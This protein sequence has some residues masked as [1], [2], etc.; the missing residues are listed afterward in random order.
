M[1]IKYQK[2]SLKIIFNTLKRSLNFNSKSFN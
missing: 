1:E 2:L